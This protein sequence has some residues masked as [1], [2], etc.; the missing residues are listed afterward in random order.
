MKRKAPTTPNKSKSPS[1]TSDRNSESEHSTGEVIEISPIEKAGK[2]LV[3]A[4]MGNK[5]R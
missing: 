2:E 3:T 1:R 5:V 4:A